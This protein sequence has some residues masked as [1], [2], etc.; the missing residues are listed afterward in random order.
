MAVVGPT[1]SA[2]RY[3]IKQKIPLLESSIRF[4][5]L[6]NMRLFLDTLTFVRSTNKSCFGAF[7]MSFICETYPV[8]FV[9]DLST[10][11]LPAWYVFYEGEFDFEKIGAVKAI[12][13]KWA[14]AHVPYVPNI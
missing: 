5:L 2:L 11:E 1:F 7:H 3:A 10:S 4:E 9:I 13:D 14:L 12:I 6:S 8:K